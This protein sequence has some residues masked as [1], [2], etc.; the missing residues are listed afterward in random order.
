MFGEIIIKELGGVQFRKP[1]YISFR[2]LQNRWRLLFEQTVYIGD[3]PMKDFQGARQ[4]GIRWIY[5]KNEDGLYSHISDMPFIRS[6][7]E[8][9]K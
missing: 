4:L 9:L 7:S 3:N 2:I 1:N 5:F 6:L 8:V